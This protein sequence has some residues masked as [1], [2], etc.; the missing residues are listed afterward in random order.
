MADL[1][2]LPATVLAGKLAS[3][4]LRALDVVEACLARIAARDGAIRA[5]VQ[6]DAERARRRARTLD[7]GPVLGPLHGLPIGVKDIIETADLPTEYGSPIYAGHR[8]AADAACVATACAAGALVLGKTATAELATFTPAAT[9][10]PHDFTHTPGGSSSGSAAAVADRMVPLAFGTQT[11]GSI[12]RP[13]S[14][15]G[16]VGY[17]PTFGF[18]S[19][20]GVKLLADSLDT[21]GAFARSVEDA[22]LLIGALT[23]R[24]E[25]L[26][27][28]RPDGTIRI[29]IVAS[30][31]SAAASPEVHALVDSAAAALA[32]AGA[33]VAAAKLPA[34]FDGLD[35][36]LEDIYGYESSRSLA[37]ERSRRAD[38]LSSRLR[39]A[40]DRGAA[41]SAERYDR[42][43]V[44]RRA[45]GLE[46]AAL[47]CEHDV[48]IAPS[49]P[50]EA[51]EGLAS[52]GDPV[53]NRAWTLLGL[54]CINVRAG[55]GPR[56]LPIGL[57]VVGRFGDDARALAAAA[58]IDERLAGSAS[59]TPSA[60]SARTVP[61]ARTE[62]SAM[63]E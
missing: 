30:R 31:A 5:W 55:A 20:A 45:C 62:P 58:W 19:R 52:T 17:K 44:S 57:Q 9:V 22:A 41:V 35:E 47:M 27:L 16:V 13:A 51:P 32:A 7:A 54:P 37:Y 60:P 40:L 36:A 63:Q 39:D 50:G 15:C 1:N 10:N 3:R 49:A 26:G 29:G 11:Q 56:G 25:L 24:K 46:V 43:Q 23:A 4:S 33:R 61:G 59:A 38:G 14:Y 18:V 6:C 12:I 2:E 21:I 42:A 34:A 28:A 48:L 8:P 53:M